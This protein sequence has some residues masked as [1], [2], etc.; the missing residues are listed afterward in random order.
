[1]KKLLSIIAVGAALAAGCRSKPPEVPPP[2]TVYPPGQGLPPQRQIHP[3]QIG[4]TIQG[5]VRNPVVLWMDGL[6]LA[7]ALVLAD[8]F[9]ARDPT[10]IVIYRGDKAILVDTRQLL[11]GVK[12][13]PLLP[14]DM[15]ELRR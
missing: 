4:V 10:S 7:R 2:W 3:Q 12:D 5:E 14:G 6:T 8:Y 1:M 11:A 13:P 15:I 9:G